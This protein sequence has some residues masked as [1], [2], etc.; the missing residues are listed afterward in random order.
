MPPSLDNHNVEIHEN[1]ERWKRKP[2]LRRVYRDFHQA[3]AKEL[4]RGVPG[5]TLELGSGVGA[6]RDVIPDCMTS[7]IFPNPWLDR[8]E[9]A[10]HLSFAD[11]SLANVI[12]FDV[13][14][15]LEFPGLALREFERALVPGG[16]VILFEPAMGLLGRFIYGCFHHEPLGLDKTITWEPEQPADRVDQYYSAQ[17]NA[18]RIFHSGEFH[19]R[20][21]AWNIVVVRYLSGLAYIG[22]GGFRGPQIYPESFFKMVAG[23][24]R[25]LSL[26]PNLFATRML[27]VLEKTLHKSPR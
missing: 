7:D 21:A 5:K 3:I 4:A 15:H 10:Y 9:N 12:L 8:V 26:V 23:C 20:L 11:E 14:H 13:W 1:M 16:R 22:T 18:W 6:I 17:G 27:V 19:E 2:L 24:D 25:G